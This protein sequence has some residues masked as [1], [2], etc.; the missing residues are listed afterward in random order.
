MKKASCSFRDFRVRDAVVIAAMVVV[1]GLPLSL[2]INYLF[3]P[4][5]RV[6]HVLSVHLALS[7]DALTAL[8]MLIFCFVL[9]TAMVVGNRLLRRF[10]TQPSPSANH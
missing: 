2:A 9:G 6:L 1:V 8:T 10:L 7:P 3:G 5:E 4:S